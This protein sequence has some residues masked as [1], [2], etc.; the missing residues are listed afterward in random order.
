MHFDRIIPVS[1]VYRVII[2]DGQRNLPTK[3]F[4]FVRVLTRN[5]WHT[6]WVSVENLMKDYL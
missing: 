1:E 2:K 3:L 5:R 4:I 6:N